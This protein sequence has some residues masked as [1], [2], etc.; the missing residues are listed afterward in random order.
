MVLVVKTRIGRQH[1]HEEPLDIP[2]GRPS[3]ENPVPFEDSP[4]VGVD[5]EEGP[6]AGIEQDAVG[7]L[8][9][10]PRNGQKPPPR[11]EEIPGKHRGQVTPEVLAQRRE[12]GFQPLCLDPEESRRTNQ[13]LQVSV[14]ETEQD[15]RFHGFPGLDGFLPDPRN[16]QKPPP[17]FEEIPGQH[18][19]QI[20]P[21]FLAQHRKKSLQPPCLDPVA[22]RRANQFLQITVIES[23]Q[24]ERFQGPPRL[25]PPDGFLH[26]RPVRVL[27]QD[28]PDGNLEGRVPRPPV[29]RTEGPVQRPVHAN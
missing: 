7:R 3:P 10:D 12:K 25:D 28:R 8:L 19:V 5:H 18:R 9:P 13:F 27:R 11:F 17:R 20:A 2:V 15:E 26:V 1:V 23:E 24:D 16:G 29:K 14:I 22:A 21:E 4:G 6:F